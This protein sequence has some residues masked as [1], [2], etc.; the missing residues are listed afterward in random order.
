MG[1][2]GGA[3][4]GNGLSDKRGTGEKRGCPSGEYS[5]VTRKT[6]D[7]R[8]AIQQGVT[9]TFTIDCKTLW[10]GALSRTARRIG[11]GLCGREKSGTLIPINTRNK[12]IMRVTKRT[13][14]L[15]F[16]NIFIF[17]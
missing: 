9:V 5:S 4:G 3:R 8:L 1:V 13:E 6:M 10:A 16:A 7:G 12:G 14:R 17:A 15:C 2:A 11:F